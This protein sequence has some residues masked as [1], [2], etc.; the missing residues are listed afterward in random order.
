V[1]PGQPIQVALRFVHD[2]HWHTYWVN[3]GTGLPTML[4]WKLP[5]G[6]TAGNCASPRRTRSGTK[7][8][9]SSATATR[10]ICCSP[11]HSRRPRTS[12]PVAP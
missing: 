6:W 8:A 4:A 1:Q 5:P 12:P 3:P 10:A 11:S 2:P 9:P 7:P